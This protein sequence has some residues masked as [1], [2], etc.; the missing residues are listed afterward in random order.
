MSNKTALFY[1]KSLMKVMLSQ[2]PTNDTQYT[3]LCVCIYIYASKCLHTY[4]FV[5]VFYYEMICSTLNLN[6][7]D[8]MCQSDYQYMEINILVKICYQCYIS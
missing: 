4:A 8:L 6:L 3:Y 2:L 5:I 1:A 7:K